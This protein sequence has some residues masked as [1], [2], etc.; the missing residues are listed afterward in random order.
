MSNFQ[1]HVCRPVELELQHSY[2]VTHK[3]ITLTQTKEIL[4][5]VKFDTGIFTF[6]SY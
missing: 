1:G 5:A 3:P 2:S 4:P 6:F